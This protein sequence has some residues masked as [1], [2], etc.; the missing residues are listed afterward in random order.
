MVDFA[1]Q[2]DD[3][4]LQRLGGGSHEA[5]AIARKRTYQAAYSSL[6]SLEVSYHSEDLTILQLPDSLHQLQVKIREFCIRTW[7]LTA[8]TN[9]L[10]VPFARST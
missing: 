3:Q 9:T 5:G 1:G 8:M 4:P 10:R 7:L 2:L 6:K